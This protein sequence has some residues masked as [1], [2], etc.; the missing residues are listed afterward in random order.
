MVF[1]TT[2]FR[3]NE[4]GTRFVSTAMEWYATVFL[5]PMPCPKCGSLHTYSIGFTNLGGI[6]GANP[7]C[8]GKSGKVWIR[9]RKSRN[10]SH[11]KNLN[12][13]CMRN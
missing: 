5:A 10:L 6:L 1:V 12:T 11:W 4:C 2:R 7:V 9:I 8:I 3:C 13:L